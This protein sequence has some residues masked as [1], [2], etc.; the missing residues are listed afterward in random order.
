MLGQRA[1][2]AGMPRATYGLILISAIFLAG[3]HGAPPPPPPVTTTTMPVDSGDLL[4][5]D[6]WGCWLAETAIDAQGQ[7]PSDGSFVNQLPNCAEG[8]SSIGDSG[9]M[10]HP[11]APPVYRSAGAGSHPSIEFTHAGNT[12]LQTNEGQPWV[13]ADMLAGS[14]TG[15]TLAWVGMVTDVNSH[16]AKYLAS[17]LDNQF[18]YP[19][20]IVEGSGPNLFAGYGGGNVEARSSNDTV[21]DDTLQGVILYLSPDGSASVLEVDGVDLVS[22]QD[23]RMRTNVAGLTLGNLFSRNFSTTDHQFLFLGLREGPMSAAETAVFWEFVD[24]L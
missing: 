12:L 22:G 21:V 7:T 18:D 6:W 11:E 3:C 19:M 16:T 23:S 8:P 14:T 5:V 20:L 15:V 10:T 1:K 13:G 2:E 17:G 9:D 4:S 24:S